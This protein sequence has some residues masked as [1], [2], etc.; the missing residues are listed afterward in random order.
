M[1][2]II[3]DQPD[4]ARIRLSVPA[5]YEQLKKSNSSLNRKP[6]K[7]LEDS[8]ERVLEVMKS[9]GLCGDDEAD[10]V[11]GDFEGLEEP[12]VK[13]CWGIQEDFSEFSRT[14]NCH[15]DQALYRKPMVLIR[16]L[17]AHG[18]PPKQH[19]RA[20]PS[21]VLPRNEKEPVENPPQSDAKPRP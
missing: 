12:P 15:I 8:L 6:K 16:V 14:R 20:R 4:E 11:E 18:P 3:D 17:S 21:Q 13:V 9:E 7:L 2:K 5:I 19:P 10:S 1:R